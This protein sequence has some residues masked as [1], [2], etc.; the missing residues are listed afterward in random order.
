M[1]ATAMLKA[2]EAEKH[3]TRDLIPYGRCESWCY[4]G[5]PSSIEEGIRAFRALLGNYPH[6]P[7]YMN[8]D[9]QTYTNRLNR[10]YYGKS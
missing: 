7:S 9:K 1:E 5:V 8:V 3:S 2:F 6:H 4:V 10:A